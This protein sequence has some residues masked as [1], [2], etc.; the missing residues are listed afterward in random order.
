MPRQPIRNGWR[1]RF[2]ILAREIIT[3]LPP[4]ATGETSHS[5][6]KST[7]KFKGTNYEEA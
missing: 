5:G 2:R 4:L 1:G 3:T 6:N 7:S